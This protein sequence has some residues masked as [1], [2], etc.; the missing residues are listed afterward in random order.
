MLTGTTPSD[1]IHRRRCTALFFHIQCVVCVLCVVVYF[2]RRRRCKALFDHI[3]RCRA[4][5]DHAVTTGVHHPSLISM[6]SMRSMRG[7]L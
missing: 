4:L 7:D 5:S 3:C 1:H 6:P 2:I